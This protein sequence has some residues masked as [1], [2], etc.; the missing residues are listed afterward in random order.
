LC[1]AWRG[2]H[3]QIKISQSPPRTR[4]PFIVLFEHVTS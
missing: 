1:A 4:V 3:T 2:T